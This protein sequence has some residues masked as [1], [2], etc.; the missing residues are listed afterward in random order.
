MSLRDGD[1][2]VLKPGM[3]LHLIPGIYEPE[4]SLLLSEPFHVTAQGAETFC[5]LERKLFVH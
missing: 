4:Y 3:C 5:K 1:K 2:T